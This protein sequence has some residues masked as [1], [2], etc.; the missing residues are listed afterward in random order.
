M[1]NSYARKQRQLSHASKLLSKIYNSGS[2]KHVNKID[3][4]KTKIRVLINELSQVISSHRIKKLL[5]G[6]ALILGI[7]FANPLSSQVKFAAPDTSAFGLQLSNNEF[8]MDLGDLDGD[9]DYDVL[10]SSYYEGWVY[11]ENVGDEKNAMFG[12]PTNNPFNLSG[13]PDLNL[14]TFVVLDADGDLDLLVTTEYSQVGYFENIG[15]AINPEFDS[16][17]VNPFGK[18]FGEFENYIAFVNFADMDNDGD[19]DIVAGL[20]KYYQEAWEYEFFENIGTAATAEFSTNSEN[21]PGLVN[22][23]YFAI[24]KT[25]D[26]DLDGDF[27]ILS[28]NYGYDGKV[29]FEF[30]ENSGTAAEPFFEPVVRDTFGLSLNEEDFSILSFADMDNDGDADMFSM[31]LFYNYDYDMRTVKYFENITI[32]SGIKLLEQDFKFDAYPNPVSN[33]ILIDTDIN[34]N[35][36]SIVDALGQ[37]HYSSNLVSSI[38]VSHL[39]SGAYFLIAIDNLGNTVKRKFIKK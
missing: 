12:T 33:E 29:F 21:L 9:G 24:G 7:A 2:N 20:Y 36:I 34:W 13:F 19:L 32:V 1:K 27:D 14:P 18:M 38:D 6:A 39:A 23:S 5:G 17:V 30:F 26:I 35:K 8:V 37:T 10:A 25:I 31:D 15:D 11:Y 22:S 4:L 28:T 16:L 3:Q